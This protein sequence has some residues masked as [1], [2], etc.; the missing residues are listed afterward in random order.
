MILPAEIDLSG[1]RKVRR[2]FWSRLADIASGRNNDQR[3]WE[4]TAMANNDKLK[5]RTIL[6]SSRSSAESFL[7]A[8]DTVRRARNANQGRPKNEEQDLLRASLVFAAAGLDSMLKEFIRDTIKKLA[9]TDSKV[10]T[11]L[12]KFVQRQIRGDSEDPETVSG[13]KFL[14][15]VLLAA[16]P[17]DRIIEGYIRELTGSSLQ[18]ADQLI[19]A[20]KALGLDP[21]SIGLDPSKLKDT[22][23]VRNKI[24]HE[25]DVNLNT[26]R[27]KQ[28]RQSRTKPELESH[29]NHLLEVAEGILKGVEDKLRSGA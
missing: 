21:N 19:K 20:T 24:I 15:S 27:G 12:E 2:A 18:S 4:R 1:M 10:Q 17:Q 23:D 8:F 9:E 22:F 29:T 14:A 7:K 5:A 6:D 13:H 3:I 16:S 26:G 11:E 28:S 25:L